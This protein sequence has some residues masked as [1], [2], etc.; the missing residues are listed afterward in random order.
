MMTWLSLELTSAFT[1]HSVFCLESLASSPC[2]GGL[3]LRLVAPLNFQEPVT[4]EYA[5]MATFCLCVCTNYSCVELKSLLLLRLF[6]VR[7]DQSDSNAEVNHTFCINH[8]IKTGN[9]ID[10][11]DSSPMVN[12]EM[13]HDYH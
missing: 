10:Q 9:E 4:V 12:S 1:A 8:R 5:Y 11:S 7:I 3:G 13:E 6:V 2:S